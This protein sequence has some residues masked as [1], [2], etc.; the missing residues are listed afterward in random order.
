[1]PA[2][3]D[4]REFCGGDGSFVSFSYIRLRSVS[5]HSTGFDTST[6]LSAGKLTTGVLRTGSL[7]KVGRFWG[8]NGVFGSGRATLIIGT[9]F[10]TKTGLEGQWWMIFWER[11][12]LFGEKDNE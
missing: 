6:K 8:K 7:R 1:M 3:Q 2:R 11:W 4:R 12:V 10:L 9:Y 5:I